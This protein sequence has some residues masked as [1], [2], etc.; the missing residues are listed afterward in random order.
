VGIRESQGMG[1]GVEL[2]CP[3]LCHLLRVGLF[4]LRRQKELGDADCSEE[5]ERLQEAQGC[6]QPWGGFSWLEAL[7]QKGWTLGTSMSCEA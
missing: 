1:V 7:H 2:T 4:L 3:G 5:G 6:F